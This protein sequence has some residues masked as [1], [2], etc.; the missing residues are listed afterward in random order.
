MDSAHEKYLTLDERYRTLFEKSADAILIIVNDKFVDCNMATVEM[1]GYKNKQELLNTHPSVLSPPTQPDGRDSF[2]KAN[3]MMSIA[4][5]KGSHRFEW[6]HKRYN[7]EVFPVEV[8]LTAI[9][10]DVGTMIH[11]VWRD[12]TDRKK[13]HELITYQAKHDL[14][15]GL[16]NRYEFERRANELLSDLKNENAEHALCYLDLDQFKVI[17][18][19]CGHMAGDE[20]L[21]QIGTVL[22][23]AIS[24][25]DVLARLGGDEFGV[26]LEHCSISDAQRVTTSILKAIQ[27]YQFIWED[28]VFRLGVSIGLVPISQYT[29]NLTDLMRDA[30]AACYTAKNKG[31]NCIHVSTPDDLEIAHHYGQLQWVTRI[32]DAFESDAFVLFAQPIVS[33]GGD[34]EK[35]CEILLRM[36]NDDGSLIPPGEFLPAAERYNLTS[37]ID[38]WVIKNALILLKEHLSIFDTYSSFSINLS[39]ECIAKPET[40]EYIKE[41]LKASGIKGENITFEV[42]ETAAISNLIYANELISSVKELGC[43]FSLDDFGS[44]L[45]SFGYLKRLPV[46]YLKIDGLFVRDIVRDK[47]DLSMVKAINEVGHLMGMRTI[48]EYVEN[49]SILDCLK[50]INVDFAQGYFICRPKALSEILQEAG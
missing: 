29:N 16:N 31:R 36:K 27:D 1:L 15:T 42:T 6:D 20:L 26:L 49:K 48:A 4:L 37:Q 22:K 19:T 23:D 17:N 5:E 13:A 11:V 46:D 47:I 34:D 33:I 7:G 50:G 14:L 35:H 2:E 38:Y 12:I 41:Q 25:R 18:D 39:G 24:S 9:P 8:L 10:S 45:S 30:D 3:E 21:R 40:L 43:K 44:G 32:N 28:R